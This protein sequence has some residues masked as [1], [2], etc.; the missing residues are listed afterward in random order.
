[1]TNYNRL[2]LIVSKR[3]GD[4]IFCTSAIAV[5][6]QAYP[7]LQLDV[8]VLTELSRQVLQFNPAINTIFV[9]PSKRFIQ[10]NQHSYDA[11]LD[12]HD[13][14]PTRNYCNSISINKFS[15][16]RVGELHQTE[17]AIDFVKR[18]FPELTMDT[19]PGYQLFPQTT[20]HQE[21][22][23]LLMQHGASLH[24]DEVLLGIHMG[25]H[26]VAKKGLKLFVRQ[27]TESKKSW[28]FEYFVQLVQRI[29]SEYP[30]VRCVLTG[31]KGELALGKKLVAKTQRTIN[32]I[33][34][35]EVLHLA[36][37][38][39]KFNAFIT[40]DTGPMHV[41]CAMKIP[42]IGLFGPTSPAL[43]G[44]WPVDERHKILRASTMRELSV[45]SVFSSLDNYIN[46]QTALCAN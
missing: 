37:L 29:E 26:G 9:K 5:I 24:K 10:K 21:A 41:A 43:T 19:I 23:Q 46:N 32:L 2:L 25:C 22:N 34:Q 11:V 45:N 14:N 20:H 38:M 33:N 8:I 31:T 28:P 44:P 18:V 13:S 39:T 27:P 1:M 40:G 6:K 4:V 16:Q 3:I 42:I 30:N 7:H 15:T 12:F 36:A 35:T 17:M